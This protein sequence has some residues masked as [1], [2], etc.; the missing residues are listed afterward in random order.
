MKRKKPAKRP[1]SKSERASPS[2]AASAKRKQEILGR[3][4]FFHEA[5]PA[6]KS[7]IER[8][9]L[10]ANLDVGARFFDRGMSCSHVALV[11]AGSVRV[12]VQGET[13][14]E[15][16]L[17]RVAPGETCPV[18]LLSALLERPAPATADVTEPLEAVV[19]PTAAFREWVA[20]DDGVRRFVLDAIAARLVD[21]L[22]LMQEITFGRLDRRLANFLLKGFRQ[23][24]GTQ[25]AIQLTHE[26]IALELSS[27]RE[28]ITRMLREFESLGAIE[29]YRGR[30]VLKNEALLATI[31]GDL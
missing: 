8:S 28:V 3:Y 21:I 2:D 14:R 31:R 29:L 19:L 27:A 25:P 15:I 7:E 6:L 4:R 24:S 30:V 10:L 26:K 11:G 18:N 23:S 22:L 9:A 17:Y 13:G 1:A 12:S 16:T 5:P 20:H